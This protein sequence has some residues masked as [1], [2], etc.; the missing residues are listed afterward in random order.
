MN[1]ITVFHPSK[2]KRVKRVIKQY[3]DTPIAI[4]HKKG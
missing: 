3:L 1:K 2:A 4:K